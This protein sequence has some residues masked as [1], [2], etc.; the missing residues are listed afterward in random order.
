MAVGRTHRSLRSL[1]RPPLNGTIVGQTGANVQKDDRL[2]AALAGLRDRF[3]DAIEVAD[4]WDADLRAV[5]ISRR[6]EWTRRVYVSL[7]RDQEGRLDV[8]LE[9][10]PKVS[11]GLPFEESGW[12]HG[13]ILSEVADVVALHRELP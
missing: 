8:A 11:S 7:A 13:L 5:G 4:H 2:I 10:P 6:G 1:L 12:H 9:L 3:G